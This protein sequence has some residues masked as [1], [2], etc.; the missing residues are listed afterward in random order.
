MEY[1]ET[2]LRESQKQRDALFAHSKSPIPTERGLLD[3]DIELSIR[4]AEAAGAQLAKAKYFL[5]GALADAFRNVTKIDPDVKG[6]PR[7]ILI[8]YQ[9]K[10][11]QLLHDEIENLAR[12]L[13][14]RVKAECNGRRS[15]L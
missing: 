2:W 11:I 14:S 4:A 15:L 9:V 8:K 12:A 10:G 7:D 6:V 3:H 13:N 1:L 5:T